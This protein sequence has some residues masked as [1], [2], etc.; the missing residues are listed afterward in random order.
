M[1]SAEDIKDDESFECSLC[2]WGQTKKIC[3]SC[4]Q[5]LEQAKNEECTSC[6]QN[7]V[8]DIIEGITNIA[9]LDDVTACASCGKEGKD[10]DMNTCNKCK[11][12]K[13]CNAACKKKHRHKHKKQC[14]RRVAELHDEQLFKQSKKEEDCPICFLRLPYLGSGTVYMACCGKLVCRGCI[15]AVQE[16]GTAGG[17]CP[18]CRTP[19]PFTEEDMLKRFQKQIDVHNDVHAIHTLGIF[20]D[21]GYVKNQNHAKALKLWHRAGKLGGSSS[22]YR[23]AGA[24]SIGRGVDVDMK[25]AI[26][27]YELAAMGGD[28]GSILARHNLGVFEALEGNMDRALKHWMI[29]VVGGDHNCL[30]KIQGMYMDGLATKGDYQIA[31]RA[32]QSFVDE[33]RSNQRDEAAAAD[34][35]YKYLGDM[36]LLE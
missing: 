15:Y 34:D 2:S 7:N 11:M 28:A 3:K 31:L 5:K 16:K 20:Y 1:S 24:Y 8:N 32:Y 19:P 14:E 26:H 18:F 10:S 21:K 13:Y 36:P 17:L 29:G 22:Y 33:I 25:K 35:D 12:V 30:T 9:V 4:E 23:I 6:E 27:Y